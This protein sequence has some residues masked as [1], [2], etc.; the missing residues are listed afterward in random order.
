LLE[1]GQQREGKGNAD[2]STMLAAHDLRQ[3][4]AGFYASPCSY[5]PSVSRIPPGDAVDQN[6]PGKFHSNP[7]MEPAIVGRTAFDL[8]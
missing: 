6:I 2:G 8:Q 5:R 3:A 7:Q 1:T 4:C